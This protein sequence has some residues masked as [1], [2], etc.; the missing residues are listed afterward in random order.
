LGKV[1]YP[2]AGYQRDAVFDPGI[3]GYI[4]LLR[5]YPWGKS[6]VG[7]PLIRSRALAK[8]RTDDG[9][10][11]TGHDRPGY[12]CAFI[13]ADLFRSFAGASSIGGQR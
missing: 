2:S 10:L 13:A 3:Y 6:G 12:A 8:R 9:V 4:C 7:G 1:A 11:A 5:V